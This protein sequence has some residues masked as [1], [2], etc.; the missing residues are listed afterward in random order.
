[1]SSKR[2][3]Q[4]LRE[5]SLTRYYDTATYPTEILHVQSRNLSDA[6]TNPEFISHMGLNYINSVT[7]SIE[8][9]ISICLPGVCGAATCTN[10]L[11]TCCSCV[12]IS[13]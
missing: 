12:E 8:S 7:F 1:M 3:I 6:T 13:R 9:D 5:A 4:K 2:W 11:A 10:S